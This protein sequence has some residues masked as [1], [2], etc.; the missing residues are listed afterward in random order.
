MWYSSIGTEPRIPGTLEY[1]I[2]VNRLAGGV[3]GRP[4]FC[5]FLVINIL[6]NWKENR[7][8]RMPLGQT[9]QR[10]IKETRG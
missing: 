5:S 1:S 9:K 7:A 8:E 4:T 3:W 6:E 10:D 2:G